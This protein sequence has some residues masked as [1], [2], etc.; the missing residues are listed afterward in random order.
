MQR[1]AGQA[2][3]H[4]AAAR[5]LLQTL[6]DH[7]RAQGRHLQPR[8]AAAAAAR[9]EHPENAQIQNEPRP[10]LLTSEIHRAAGPGRARA[11]ARAEPAAQGG[12]GA[13]ALA[14]PRVP[15]TPGGAASAPTTTRPA[16]VPSAPSSRDAGV[17]AAGAAA[18]ARRHSAQRAA[19]DD[20][21]VAGRARARRETSPIRV[22]VSRL[23]QKLLQIFPPEGARPDSHGRAAVP[24][25]LARLRAEVLPVRRVVE[26][27]AHAHRGEEVR[28]SRVQPPVHALGPPRQARE[29]TRQGAGAARAG[30]PAAPV[31]DAR[32]N[33]ALT[34]PPTVI[35]IS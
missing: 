8:A 23:R 35:Q 12:G 15:E 34:R 26:A 18:H 32:A 22:F 16:S 29:E 20:S 10:H 31:A 11:R 13:R 6:G 4:H 17:G 2:P 5:T 28:L 9:H 7:A 33:R 24:L 30:A 21:R 27:Q 1:R 14:P 25:R 19:P 3:P